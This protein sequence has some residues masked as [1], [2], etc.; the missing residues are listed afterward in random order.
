M[1]H[2]VKVALSIFSAN[3]RSLRGADASILPASASLTF[4]AVSAGVSAFRF[5]T[6][7]PGLFQI[8]IYDYADI[9][10]MMPRMLADGRELCYLVAAICRATRTRRAASLDA[11]GVAFAPTSAGRQLHPRDDMSAPT[12]SA[13]R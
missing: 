5:A 13:R 11:S 1:R 9:D 10:L 12:Q 6:R 4:A 2:S 8:F 7:Q 3:I